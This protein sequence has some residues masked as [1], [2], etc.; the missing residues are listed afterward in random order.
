VTVEDK[1]H[2][3]P[4]DRL[5]Q[6]ERRGA[7][8][9]AADLASRLLEEFDPQHLADLEAKAN[10]AKGASQS[11]IADA[12]DAATLLQELYTVS[13]LHVL[14]VARSGAIE[15]AAELYNKYRIAERANE[16]AQSLGARLIKDRA[17][18]AS[19]AE[20]IE[21]LRQAADAYAAVYDRFGGSFPA[22]NAATLN[23]L[24]GEEAKAE[25]YAKRTL[26][27]CSKEKPDTERRKYYR[28]ASI[29][30][31]LLAGGVIAAAELALKK[32]GSRP[33]VDFGAHATTAKQLRLVCEARGIDTSILKHISVP[34]VLYFAGHI[35]SASGEDGRFP[36]DQEAPVRAEIEHYLDR[37]RPSI[38]YGSLAAGA[39]ILFAEACIE[40]GI[41]LHAILPFNMEDFFQQS[42]AP[43]GGDWPV[44][45]ERCLEHFKSSPGGLRQALT[46]ATDGKFLRDESLYMYGAQLAMGLALLRAS[47]LGTGMRMA[48]V[49]D[50]KGGTGVGTDGSIAM[51]EELGLPY[52]VIECPG[53][54][55]PRLDAVPAPPPAPEDQRRIRYPRA[56]IFGDV[57]GFSKL[58]EEDVPRF[59]D[60]FMARISKELKSFGERVLY[61]NSWGDAIYVVF[62]DAVDA[63]R[64]SLSIQKIIDAMDFVPIGYDRA[65][66]LRLGAHFG[67]IY[68][69]VDQLCEVETYYGSHVTRAARIEP[70]TPAGKVYVTESMAAALALSGIGDIDSDYVGP[71]P[72]AK[73]YGEIRMY[74]LREKG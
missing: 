1:T 46:F 5:K 32:A 23:L 41:E 11:D 18:E 47:V 39:D 4:V 55:G 28:D 59:H 2:L 74:Q 62:D 68:H 72:L 9:E 26:D 10:V 54:S 13:F 8:F 45:F 69:G 67:P 17:F 61:R 43:S 21:L 3:D 30:E 22:V 38:A 52:D 12:A 34:D 37:H 25:E 65:L 71:V 58:Q 20:R 35:I 16:D 14:V 29:A 44:R 56:I 31:A 27:A 63:A 7:Y 15:N 53:G 73:D 48:V 19:G 42:V 64:F 70:V 60:I 33:D 66:R 6:L 36:A 49:Y 51:W 40:R 50:G 24:A 57:V